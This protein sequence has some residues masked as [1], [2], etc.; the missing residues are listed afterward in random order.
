MVSFAHTLRYSHRPSLTDNL[1]RVRINQV[2]EVSLQAKVATTK[3]RRMQ[4]YPARPSKASRNATPNAINPL[5]TIITCYRRR[6]LNMSRR[7]S[8]PPASVAE[9]ESK[10]VQTPPPNCLPSILPLD[11]SFDTYVCNV[12]TTTCSWRK[13][14]SRT[15][16]AQG[17]QKLQTRPSLPA[18]AETATHLTA[19][20]TNAA[21][22]TT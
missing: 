17:R 4:R 19:M 18:P 16:S 10:P 8:P 21:G 12:S 5:L 7:R 15:R 13:S 20:Q 6:S 2:W 3:T 1:Y 11:A 22:L 9:R 14:L